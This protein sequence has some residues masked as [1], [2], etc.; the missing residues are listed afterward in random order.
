MNE[1]KAI[2]Q[3]KLFARVSAAIET[4]ISELVDNNYYWELTIQLQVIRQGS[5]LLL[6]H[7]PC[8]LVPSE[9]HGTY[10]KS[11]MIDVAETTFPE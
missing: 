10:P 5:S 2:L 9:H 3:V 6:Q 1:F 8:I 4:F 7:S 11:L